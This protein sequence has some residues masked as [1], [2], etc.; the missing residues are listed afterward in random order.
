VIPHLDARPDPLFP[1]VQWLL[2]FRLAVAVVGI[3]LTLIVEGGAVRDRAPYAVLIAAVAADLLYLAIA[4]RIVN[5]R[6]FAMIQIAIDG[7]IESAL[8][9]LTGGVY[10]FAAILY[11]AS[12]LAAS[13]CVS[14]RFSV[15]FASG[16]TVALASIQ[17]AYHFAVAPVGAEPLIS[18]PFVPDMVLDEHRIRIERVAAYLIS[19]GLALHLVAGLSS[20]LAAELRRTI[21]LYGEI[22]QK[23][24]EGVIAVDK[25][26]RIV[27]VNAEALALLQYAR[28]DDIVGKDYRDVFKRK[29][30][31]DIL[32]SLM[33]K[34]PVV[35]EVE[36]LMRDGRKRHIEAKTS[37]LRDDRG[38]VRGTI[39]I[40]TDRTLKK[41]AETAEKRAE[42]LEGIEALAMGIAHEVRNP[43]ASI[44]GCV[45]E[46]GRLKYLGDDERQL[47]RIV[48]RESDRLDAIIGEFLQF[49]RLKP[50]DLEEADLGALLR[51][52][53]LLLKGRLPPTAA[54]PE[55]RIRIDLDLI[56]NARVK[57]DPKQ[58]TQVFL[59]L[60][61]NALESLE[62]KGGTLTISLK[63]SRSV[64]HAPTPRGGFRVLEDVRVYEAAFEDTG[65]GV[66]AKDLSKIF[67]PFYTTKPGGTGLGLS[68]AERIVKSH[69]GTIN[70]ESMPLAGA[71]FRVQLPALETIVAS[72]T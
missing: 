54:A 30:D 58:L 65:E 11:F 34:E 7:V 17:V 27:F 36:V 12:I 37:L 1:R 32:E 49:A 39:G 42:R 6:R 62:K 28:G 56:E 41:Q 10:S 15:L 19:M 61:I 9:Y 57:A 70:A 67:E 3:V 24:A 69:G 46:L 44:R 47:A 16:A 22:L 48:C 51:E 53:A 71:A 25:D 40:F 13:L 66:D 26:G 60:G 18:L 21:V 50:P 59:N 35:V 8:C 31:R 52:V 33:A 55:A 72:V 2:F 43:L 14:S 63:D 45:Q 4:R 20:W 23:M 64:R 29:E 68:I 5:L 38:L